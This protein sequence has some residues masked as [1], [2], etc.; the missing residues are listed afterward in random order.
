M[1]RSIS[2]IAAGVGMLC[3][4]LSPLTTSAKHAPAPLVEPA[5]PL[6]VSSIASPSSD[7]DAPFVWTTDVAFTP[8][9]PMSDTDES[10]FMLPGSSPA[11]PLP[12]AGWTGLVGLAGLGAISLARR[13]RRP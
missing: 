4:A 7:Q 9:L 11:V 13:F 3:A 12:P 1:R 5:E 6:H 2:A 8:P 10:P